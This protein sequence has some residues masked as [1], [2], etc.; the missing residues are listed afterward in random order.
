[1][2][3]NNWC[4]SAPNLKYEKEA[5]LLLSQIVH[6]RSQKKFLRLQSLDFCKA[7]CSS[8]ARFL[9]VIPYRFELCY[10]PHFRFAQAPVELSIFQGEHFLECQLKYPL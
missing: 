10:S 7:T 6:G 4:P 9:Y 2:E 3:K 1:M 8:C 5:A